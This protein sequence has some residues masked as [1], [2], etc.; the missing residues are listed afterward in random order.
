MVYFGAKRIVFSNYSTK[1][2]CNLQFTWCVFC[3]YEF[4]GI[5]RKIQLK[6]Q[7]YGHPTGS[8]DGLYTSYLTG[9]SK[10]VLTK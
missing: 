7:P 1:K 5:N 10:S 9:G 2:D 8:S 4:S 6:Y 3:R